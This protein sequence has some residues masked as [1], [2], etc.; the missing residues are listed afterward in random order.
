MTS[1]CGDGG[2]VDEDGDWEREG[3]RVMVAVRTVVVELVGTVRTVERTVGT[4][5]VV[6]GTVRTM[7][8]TVVVVV[9]VMAVRSGGGGRAVAEVRESGN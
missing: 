7:V 2:G 4:V 1:S 9:M 5:V 3:G 6:V 8:R